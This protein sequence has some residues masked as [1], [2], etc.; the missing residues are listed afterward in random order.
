MTKVEKEANLTKLEQDLADMEAELD[1]LLLLP[2][3]R[4]ALGYGWG[5]ALP[6]VRLGYGHVNYYRGQTL[7]FPPVLIISL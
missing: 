2:P 1:R 6:G 5:K 3:V 7:P 4:R